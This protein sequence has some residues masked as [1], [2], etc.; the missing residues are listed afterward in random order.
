MTK[1]PVARPPVAVAVSTGALTVT[2]SSPPRK[3]GPRS[4]HF[5]TC[6]GR[7]GEQRVERQGT[8]MGDNR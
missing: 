4:D 6:C 2:L 1:R 3:E 5:I 8:G 7:G